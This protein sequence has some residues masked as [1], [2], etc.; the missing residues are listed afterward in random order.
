MFTIEECTVRSV[1]DAF[2][3]GELTSASLV[4]HYMERIARYDKSGPKLHTCNTSL[5][6]TCDG[7][8]RVNLF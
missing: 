6:Y 3:K 5:L 1:R 8:C 2:E 4:M 7:F